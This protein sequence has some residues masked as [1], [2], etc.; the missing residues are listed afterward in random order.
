MPDDIDPNPTDPQGQ[1]PPHGEPDP[2]SL[3]PLTTAPV[4]TPHDA[5]DSADDSVSDSV[6]DGVNGSADEGDFGAANESLAGALAVS[7]KVLRVVLL[8]LILIFLLSGFFTVQ[9]NEVAVR[10]R[11]GKIVPRGGDGGEVLTADG[12]PY[13]RWPAP[14]GQVYRIP[15]GAQTLD[16]DTAFVFA[17]A[18]EPANRGKPL[19]EVN[20]PPTLDPE[21]DGA[22]LTGD[23]GLIHARF[24][25]S[26]QIRP[27]GA[28]DFVRN[29]ADVA[30]LD[31]NGDDPRSI[32]RDAERLVRATVEQAIVADVAGTRLDALLTVGRADAAAAQTSPPAAAAETPPAETPPAATPAAAAAPGTPAPAS[33]AQMQERVRSQA[34]RALDA[35]DTGIQVL[36]VNAYQ[37]GPP[38]A[39]RAAFNDL[40]IA[41]QQRGNLSELATSYSR[42]QFTA[43]AGAAYTAVLAVIDVYEDADRTR[44]ASPEFYKAAETALDA[45]L[46]GRPMG[47]VLPPLADALPADDPR[48]GQLASLARTFADQGLGGQASSTVNNARRDVTQY[49]ADLQ[50]EADAFDGLLKDYR[51]APQTVRQQL[52]LRTLS[53]ILSGSDATTE[54]LPGGRKIVRLLVNEDPAVRNQRE[55]QQ[56]DAAVRGG[57]PP[58]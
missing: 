43:A 52:F 41:N 15:T 31:R 1:P 16:L 34:Q 38:I 36:T 22:L 54:V 12:G 37:R 4:T 7:F 33:V 11:F 55:Q 39:V 26:Y 58:Q 5:D 47:Q 49:L 18:A 24:N 14:V 9:P 42:G 57:G 56:R 51:K 6:S 46:D 45:A 2:H 48:R 35:L 19:N 8:G 30:E 53:S 3:P 21:A 44:D 29:V 23:K 27:E 20:G 32:F 25:V 28:A 40:S 50:A 17:A 10:T 13:F